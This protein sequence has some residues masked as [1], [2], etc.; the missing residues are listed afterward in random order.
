VD[1]KHRIKKTIKEKEKMAKRGK[2]EKKEAT[3]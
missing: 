2:V 1:S 3:G